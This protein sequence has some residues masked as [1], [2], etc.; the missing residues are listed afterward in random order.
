MAKK[1]TDYGEN[2][3]I[4]AVITALG[5]GAVGIIRLSGDSAASIGNR[6]FKSISGKKL[7][8]YQPNL[9]VYGHAVDEENN[10]IDE[11]LAVY[12]PR[13]HSYTAEDVVEI[14]CHGGL[15][16]LKA[17]LGLTYKLGARPAEP[18]EF[19][20]RAFL[21]G[22]IDLVQAEAVMDIIK[23]RSEAALK[24]AVRQ[25]G[26][27]LSQKIKGLRRSLMDIVVNLEAVIDYPEDDIEEIT[28]NKVTEGMNNVK[29]GLEDLLQHAHTGKILREGLQTV[30]VGRPN[31]GKSSLLNALLSEERAIVSEYAGT[32]RDVIEEQL[33][34]GGVPLVLVDTAGIRHTED[35]VEQIGVAKSKEKLNQAEL[36]IVVLDGSQQLNAEDEEILNTVSNKPCVIILNKSDQPQVNNQATLAK[37]FGADRVI[38]LSAKTG[39][40][41][42]KFTAWLQKYV[43]GSEQ[44]LS[45]G[46]YVQNVRHENLL[47]EALASVKDAVCAAEAMLPYDCIIIDM[48]KAIDAMGSITGDTVQDEIIN[49]IFSKF[50]V[51]K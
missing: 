14:Q 45:G 2:E 31:V 39:R 16:S 50:C 38:P 51:G 26:G 35:Y 49:E 1:Y 12:M 7:S 24:M 36:A 18:G 9:L 48:H 44:A 23:S 34:L 15:A 22:R 17:I 11:V 8:E 40:G 29:E 46:A 4:S 43:Y 13:P 3:T 25:H 28:F 47:R 33:L 6:I 10:Q 37:R 42:E 41:L 5:E 30:I 19:T 32:T 20:K 27:Q 21:N